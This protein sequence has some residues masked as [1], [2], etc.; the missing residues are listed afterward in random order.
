MTEQGIH[1]CLTWDVAQRLQRDMG[2]TMAPFHFQLT[3]GGLDRIIVVLP[4]TRR[5]FIPAHRPIAA[6][7]HLG[8]SL[9]LLGNHQHRGFLTHHQALPRRCRSLH[10]D[11]RHPG[12]NPTRRTRTIHITIRQA[13]SAP[14]SSLYATV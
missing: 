13:L 12:F 2:P 3:S 8:L 10:C 1:G 6:S 9:K 14:E 11:I 4:A 7:P 5:L